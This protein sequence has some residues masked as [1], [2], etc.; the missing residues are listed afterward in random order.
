MNL[1]KIILTVGIIAVVGSAFAQGGG[2]GQRRG[3]MGGQMG[4]GG[5]AQLLQRE[6]V[7]TELKLTDDQK[8]KLS[9][10][11][12]KMRDKMREMFAGGGG[13]E[14]PDPTKMREAFTKVNEEIQKEVDAILTPEQQKRLK[15][16][17]VQRAGNGAVMI[18]SV[19]KDLGIT[20]EQKTKIENL[21]KLQ[22]EATQALFQKMRDGELDGEQMRE[23]M[24]ANQKALDEEIGK[25]LTE[26]QKTKLKEMAGKPFTF[27]PDRPRGGGN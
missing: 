22:G 27:S 20:D 16:L 19:A 4:R 10:L 12:D 17:S 3:M 15:E 26:A 5:P 14:R 18:P 13:G 6:E 1:K 7:Q 9:G 8:T 23:K 21:Q 11:Q 2:G 25:V 24:T